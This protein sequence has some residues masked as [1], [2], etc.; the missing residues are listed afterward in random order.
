M[1]ISTTV[2]QLN[3]SDTDG[4]IIRGEEITVTPSFTLD[5][6]TGGC[7]LAELEYNLYNSDGD[8]LKT[9]TYNITI[10]SPEDPA[11]LTF[12]YTP[13]LVGD[14]RLVTTLEECGT[15]VTDATII[16]ACDYINI[17]STNCHEYT[18]YNY[19]MT[20]DLWVLFTDKLNDILVALT[21]IDPGQSLTLTTPSDGIYYLRSYSDSGNTLLQLQ[22]LIDTCDVDSCISDIS[23]SMLC[24]DCN[25]TKCEDYCEKLYNVI[26]IEMLAFLLYNKMNK[27]Y[28]LNRIYTAIDDTKASEMDNIATLISQISKYCSNCGTTQSVTNA[29][30]SSGSSGDCGCGG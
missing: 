29:T 25:T 13:T 30:I 27:E 23:L 28:S 11:D 8:L 16:A 3:S 22:I 14:L 10:A 5:P 1:N 18:V 12:T 26:Q 7:T 2:T 15:T 9:T 4:C 6:P 19:S 21:K 24:G 17:K 20:T